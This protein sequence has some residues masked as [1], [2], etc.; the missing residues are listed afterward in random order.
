VKNERGFALIEAVLLG[1]VLIVPLIWV[2]AVLSAVHQGALAATSAAREAGVDAARAADLHGASSAVE[3]AVARA[4][5]DHGLDPTEAQIR[6][7]AAPDL[8]RGGTIEVVIRYPIEVLRAPL[9]G[10]ISG[11][12]VW[13][14]ARNVT[15]IEPFGS[16]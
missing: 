15:R 11:P 2:L 10:E 4:F 16:R 7:S 1:L 8:A 14:D 13:I 6:F 5:A 12:A 3:K 9:L